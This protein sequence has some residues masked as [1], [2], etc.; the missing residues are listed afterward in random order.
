MS[1]RIGEEF[2][3]KAGSEEW[4]R[5]HR[6][7]DAIGSDSVMT[8]NNDRL[9][10]ASSR[11]TGALDLVQ[12]LEQQRQ[13]IADLNTRLNDLDRKSDENLRAAQERIAEMLRTANKTKDGRAVF[14]AEDGTIYDQ[15]GTVVGAD[16]VDWETWDAEAESWEDYQTALADRDQAADLVAKV[17]GLQ[18]RLNAG[19]LS[20][21]DLSVVDEELTAL[22]TSIPEFNGFTVPSTGERSTSAA[23]LY[24][25]GPAPTLTVAASFGQ[26]VAGETAEPP[27]SPAT[28]TPLQPFTPE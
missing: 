24:E 23:K 11:R 18:D 7:L 3:I 8:T 25:T 27:P 15:D 4:W 10:Q 5:K 9:H 16:E 19:G 26:A 20:D 14:Q 22:E 2:A 21:E 13:R 28:L 6:Y 17:D 1:L 12:M